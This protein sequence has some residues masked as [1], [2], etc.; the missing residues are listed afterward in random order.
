MISMQGSGTLFLPVD[1]SGTYI[2]QMA[3]LTGLISI[4]FL[5]PDYNAPDIEGFGSEFGRTDCF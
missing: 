1:V 5:T 4:D 3:M 2:L